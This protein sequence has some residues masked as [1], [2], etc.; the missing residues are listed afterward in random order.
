[1]TISDSQSLALPSA[2]IKWNVL[3]RRRGQIG[4]A[5]RPDR[6]DLVLRK[7]SRAK[8]SWNPSTEWAATTS[9][10]ALAAPPTLSSPPPATTSDA[11]WP[12]W[13]FFAPSS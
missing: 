9:P 5:L 3:R 12:G 10:I 2:R 7:Q 13:R 11:C 1:M 8:L 6:V 4:G